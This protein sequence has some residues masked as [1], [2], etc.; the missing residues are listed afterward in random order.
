MLNR[1]KN[2]NF[3]QLLSVVEVD[4]TF[5]VK[6]PKKNASPLHLD[7]NKLLTVFFSL[8]REMGERYTL[9]RSQAS[10]GTLKRS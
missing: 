1:V 7:V 5:C 9:M 4:D 8:L 2:V 6:Q 10:K 3:H